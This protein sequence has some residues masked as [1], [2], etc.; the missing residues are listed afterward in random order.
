MVPTTD[1]FADC[2]LISMAFDPDFATNKFV[3]FG[4]CTGQYASKISRFT[5]DGNAITDGVDIM[6]WNGAG[7]ANTWHSVGSMGFDDKK[8]LWMVHGEFTNTAKAQDLNTNLGKLIRIIPSRMAGVGDYMPAADNPFAAEPKP[9]SALYAYGLRSPW[10]AIIDSKGRY[11]FGDVGNQ[12]N[13][14]IN[15]VT[16]KGLNFG[17]GMSADTSGACAAPCVSP[18]TFWKGGADPYRGT[19]DLRIKRPALGSSGWERN[20]ATVA[21]TSTKAR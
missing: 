5:Y 12:R 17:W 10:R 7:G 11:I 6:K 3:Y 16:A 15:V 8:N 21:T 14:E 2:G 19:G 20:T 9:K 1:A 18:V 13:E 4:L